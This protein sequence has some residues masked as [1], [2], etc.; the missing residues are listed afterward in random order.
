MIPGPVRRKSQVN[1]V[2]TAIDPYPECACN[3]TCDR[4]AH[5]MASELVG[6]LAVIAL[7]RDGHNPHQLKFGPMGIA[8][9]VADALWDDTSEGNTAA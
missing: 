9:T 5:E 4:C 1:Y 7:V 3:G 6:V 2:N 8:R